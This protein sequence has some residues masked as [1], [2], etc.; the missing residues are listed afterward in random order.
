M[1]VH[2]DASHGKA[3]SVNPAGYFESLGAHQI[4]TQL[5]RLAWGGTLPLK[6]NGT[7]RSDAHIYPPDYDHL[8]T[9][10]DGCF[11]MMQKFVMGRA[12]APVWGFKNPKTALTI[13]CWLPHLP[14]PHL[15]ALYRHPL[16]NAQAMSGLY[17]MPFS[18]ALRITEQY[19]Q[20]ISRV[21]AH[22]PTIPSVVIRFEDIVEKYLEVVELLEAFL[23]VEATGEALQN[24]SMMIQRGFTTTERRSWWINPRQYL[25]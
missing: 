23:G 21:L 3:D 8:M 14:D 17:R 15:I 12:R 25:S 4:N 19:N 18:E 1:G 16:D 7:W 13:E 5:F 9:H 24:I 2:M 10:R 22:N 11:D 6:P 20:N